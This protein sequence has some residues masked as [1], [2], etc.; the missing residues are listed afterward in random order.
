[1]LIQTTV[2][3]YWKPMVQG[4]RRASTCNNYLSI[5]LKSKGSITVL[6]TDMTITAISIEPR[7]SRRRGPFAVHAAAA[8]FPA[9]AQWTEPHFRVHV[10][11]FPPC[12]CSCLGYLLFCILGFW[13][14]LLWNRE[15]AET[16]IWNHG[17]SRNRFFPR[18]L[19]LEIYLVS[20]FMT[21]NSCGTLNVPYLGVP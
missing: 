12:S 13:K 14:L 1:M 19:H 8:A 9:K 6:R 10:Q 18:L 21:I 2:H 11:T 5:K 7:G 20:V 16:A 4:A 3:S 15:T 17:N